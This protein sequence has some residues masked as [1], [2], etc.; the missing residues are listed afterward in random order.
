MTFATYIYMYVAALP[1]ASSGAPMSCLPKRFSWL[2]QQTSSTAPC[3][4][5]RRGARLRAALLVSKEDPRLLS[6]VLM[7]IVIGSAPLSSLRP[8]HGDWCTPK[9][10]VRFVHVA[11]YYISVVG[12]T[13]V[14]LL[15]LLLICSSSSTISIRD[16]NFNYYAG[17][18]Y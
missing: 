5:E 15:L 11:F 17:K 3:F 12:F 7:L 1:S 16:R 18:K 2:V 10:V 14:T 6:A 13:I 9:S 8:P 4:L